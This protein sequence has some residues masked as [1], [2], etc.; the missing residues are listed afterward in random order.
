[1]ISVHMAVLGNTVPK[2][3]SRNKP[4]G[5]SQGFNWPLTGSSLGSGW[6]P[7]GQTNE[8]R[9]REGESLLFFGG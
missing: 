7:V 4:P 9:R 5:R 2:T 3:Q 6:A 8:E 1:M